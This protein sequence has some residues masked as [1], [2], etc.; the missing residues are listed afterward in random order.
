MLLFF[1]SRIGDE[2]SGNFKIGILFDWM[3]SFLHYLS[4]SRLEPRI[5]DW[6]FKFSFIFSSVCTTMKNFHQWKLFEYHVRISLANHQHF[7]G[8]PWSKNRFIN[9]NQQC[10]LRLSYFKSSS[11]SSFAKILMYHRYTGVTNQYCSQG[12]KRSSKQLTN[13]MV[14]YPLFI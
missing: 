6:R 13:A 2:I 4:S 5:K 9:L 1:S 12:I 7:F 8:Y 10:N 11:T 14:I 3:G